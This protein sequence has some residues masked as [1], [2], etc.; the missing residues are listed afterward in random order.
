MSMVI[1]NIKDEAANAKR[2]LNVK[3]KVHRKNFAYFLVIAA[4]MF[5]SNFAT[6]V[7]GIWNDI[8]IRNHE[9]SDF[10]VAFF[11]GL[12]I[13][14]IIIMLM[15]RQTND[16]LSVF[17]QS[18]TGRFIA[19]QI[20]NYIIVAMAG[21]MSLAMYLI[22][23]C[24]MRFLSAAKNNVH[25]ALNADAG[26]IAAGF[27]TFTAYS[28]LILAAI[29][30]VGAILRK[31]AHYA[32]VAFTALLALAFVNIMTVVEYTP[33][34]LAFLVRE[35]SFAV[36]MAKAAA[37]WIALVAVS[38]LINYHTEYYRS[39]NTVIKKAVVIVCIIIASAILFITPM[40]LMFTSGSG[41]GNAM[42]TYETYDDGGFAD[43]TF[44]AASEIRIDVS[45]LPKG[46]KLAL[47]GDN[48]NTRGLDIVNGDVVGGK[49]GDVADG[50]D[51]GDG[52]D[53]A[54]GAAEYEYIIYESRSVASYA[55][56]NGAEALDD[57]RGDAV[58]VKF[59][60]PEYT[61]NGVEMMR[62]ANPRFDAYLVD[63]ALR[64]D[65]YVDDAH[66]VFVPIWGIARQFDAFKDKGYYKEH[67]LGYIG[68]GNMSPSIYISV[69]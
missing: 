26:F 39:H 56:I 5:I 64:I 60:P 66:V 33:K 58:V 42:A 20:I 34:A 68:G 35:P 30:L 62:F 51:G 44:P 41:G 49:D 12:I 38:L 7:Y 28:F 9:L 1:A 4:V 8:G 55:N 69:E 6:T 52:G 50:G 37:L 10:S 57:I 24:S 59:R 32:A 17:P 53:G 46:S 19:S 65:Y 40:V 47:V 13:A 63:G 31:W 25:L 67:L 16:K 43:E 29:D 23:Y 22:N 61:I 14:F 54:D 15:Y 48:F 45:H 27:F 11:F 36:F 3:F 18:N 2:L 21:L